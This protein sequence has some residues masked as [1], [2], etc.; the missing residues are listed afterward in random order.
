MIKHSRG[1]SI[2]HVVGVGKILST[3]G[4]VVDFSK[5]SKNDFSKGVEV[6]NFILPT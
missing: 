4:P 3:G 6:V 1:A 5:G 2:P